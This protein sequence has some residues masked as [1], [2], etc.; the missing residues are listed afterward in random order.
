MKNFGHGKHSAFYVSLG[1]LV[2]KP[3]VVT[4][5]SSWCTLLTLY[6]MAGENCRMT[7]QDG[8]LVYIWLPTTQHI[9]YLKEV[10]KTM[11]VLSLTYAREPQ[12]TLVKHNPDI[13]KAVLMSVWSF[14]M[15]MH[16]FFQKILK[17]RF[18][19]LTGIHVSAWCWRRHGGRSIARVWGQAAADTQ[20]LHIDIWQHCG[21]IQTHQR[22]LWYVPLGFR[23]L[24][25]VLSE[26]VHREALGQTQNAQ[27]T[28]WRPLRYI[29]RILL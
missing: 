9:G 12:S 24:M 26:S 25:F 17:E 29:R 14:N 22:P 11:H 15:K 23:L 13:L 4:T 1:L 7:S 3:D 21:K 20:P 28:I 6:I 18:C 10:P 5:C 16:I 27:S 8:F 2:K 19:D